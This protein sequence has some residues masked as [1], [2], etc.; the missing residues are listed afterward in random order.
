MIDALR[1]D[2]AVPM[3]GRK[4]ANLSL[5]FHRLS[6]SI[7]GKGDH[8]Q[9]D[10]MLDDMCR[11]YFDLSAP[12][13]YMH[14]LAAWRALEDADLD[15]EFFEMKLASRLICGM[16]NK[17]VQECGAT[18][19]M[20][21]GVPYI[22]GSA[23][24]GIASAHAHLN[25][26]DDWQKAQVM[27]ARSGGKN[28]LLVFGGTDDDKKSYAA[29]VDFMDAWW[30]PEG[31][32]SP[33]EQDILTPHNKFYLGSEKPTAP[34]GTDSPVPVKFLV[35]KAGVKFLFGL[36]GPSPLRK[37]VRQIITEALGAAGPGLGSKTRLGYGRF[38][39]E[40][41]EREKQAE[42]EQRGQEEL[43]EFLEMLS[44][45]RI[46]DYKG[47]KK[48]VSDNGLKEKVD[49]K[50]DLARRIYAKAQER[51]SDKVNAT[52]EGWHT[53]FGPAE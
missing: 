34:D 1:K 42:Q 51:W 3:S 14:A 52:A 43:Q 49:K 5:R 16:G 39:W 32:A 26:G 47:A 9:K 48:Y 13:P 24:K 45:G 20:P 12:N 36:R 21:W 37:V 7:D 53:A 4:C 38:T 35:I 31:D 29:G 17:N 2:L 15:I 40:K 41:S 25:G 8:G 30:L 22:P 27:P 6:Q 28:A 33:F 23:V 11:P 10:T 50:G 44:D 46:T 19:L 18:F